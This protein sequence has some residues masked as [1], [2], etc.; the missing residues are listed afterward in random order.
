V[1]ARKLNCAARNEELAIG[2][3]QKYIAHTVENVLNINVSYKNKNVRKYNIIK[4]LLI[5]SV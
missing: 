3:Y 2:L 5:G 1:T 4:L